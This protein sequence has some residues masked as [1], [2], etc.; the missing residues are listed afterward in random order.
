MIRA[1]L[2]LAIGFSFPLLADV[3]HDGEPNRTGATT[4]SNAGSIPISAQK[5]TAG[6]DRYG[7][8]CLAAR[9][10]ISTATATWDSVAMDEIGH[11]TNGVR[12]AWLFGIVNPPTAASDVVATFGVSDTQGT[13]IVSSYNGVDQM[14]PVDAEVEATGTTDPASITIT[15]AAGD[16]LVDCLHFE[17]GATPP[18]EGADQVDNATIDDTSNW[19]ASSRQA[20]ADGGAM[21]W[22]LTTPTRWAQVGV[23]MNAAGGGGGSATPAA[24]HLQRLMNSN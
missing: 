1:L 24:L 12:Q 23:N 5:T 8:A 15:T 7:I 19:G 6:S 14:T 17:G 18:A 9:S 16:M 13:L 2:L 10:S 11:V 3:A 4:G 21:T 20:G 22:T